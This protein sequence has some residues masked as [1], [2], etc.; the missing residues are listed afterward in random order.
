MSIDNKPTSLLTTVLNHKYG[1]EDAEAQTEQL[2]TVFKPDLAKLADT[3]G[4]NASK[5]VAEL[6]LMAKDTAMTDDQKKILQELATFRMQ[7]VKDIT[8]RLFE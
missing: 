3:L 5:D 4:T 7:S 2:K 6:L 1:K 8:A